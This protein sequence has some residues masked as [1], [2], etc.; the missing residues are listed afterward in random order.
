VILSHRWKFIFIK[1]GKTAGTSVEIA[2]SR[3]CGPDDVITPITPEDESLRRELGYRGPQNYRVPFRYYTGEDWKNLV[4]KRRRREYYNHMPASELMTLIPR[5]IWDS[6]YTF[7]IER[8]PWDRTVSQ[9]YHKMK[10]QDENTFMSLDEYVRSRAS[11]PMKNY[12]K[13]TVDG[14]I[15][16][17]RVILFENLVEELKEV[18]KTIG[19]DTSDFSIPRAKSGVRKDKRHYRE[20]LSPESAEQIRRDYAGEIE[21]FGYEF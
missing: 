21:A 4:L 18:L 10:D 16:V 8:N 11:N 20:L 2:L 12:R 5:D 6:Y 9:Y 15:V 1:T 19:I 7:S 3:Y 14:R 17:D 13:Y